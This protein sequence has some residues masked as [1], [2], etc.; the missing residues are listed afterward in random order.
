MQNCKGFFSFRFCFFVEELSHRPKLKLLP[1]TVKD[2]VLEVADKTQQMSIFGGAKPRDETKYQE[3]VYEE[4]ANE[5]L[6]GDE[7]EEDEWKLSSSNEK[8]GG[9]LDCPSSFKICSHNEDRSRFKKK[10]VFQSTF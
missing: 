7:K 1:R 9:L 10:Q 2:P 6:G 8:T 4:K 3:K 5:K